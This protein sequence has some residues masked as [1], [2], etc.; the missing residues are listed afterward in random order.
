[1]ILPSGVRFSSRVCDKLRRIEEGS[2]EGR[3]DEEVIAG[4][5]FKPR[6]SLRL[7]TFER[8]RIDPSETLAD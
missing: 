5:F 7:E 3:E 1:M 2:G 4:T 8:R 6:G